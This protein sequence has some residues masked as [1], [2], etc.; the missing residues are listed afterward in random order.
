MFKP[1][2]RAFLE[3][4]RENLGIYTVVIIFF[5]AGI[6]S[7]SVLLRFL[8]ESQLAE[9]N[10]AVSYFM[11]GLKNES[12][13][14]LQPLDLL[15][16]SLQK[17]ILF[18]FMLW[19]L[20]FLWIGFPFIL[21]V[22]ALKGFALGFTVAFIVYRS[23]LKGLIFCLAAVLPHNLL[24]LPAY[25]VAA[26]TALTLSLLKLKERLGKKRTD[27]NHYYRGYCYLMLLL[28]VII[29]MGGLVEAYITPVFMRLVISII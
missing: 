22:L 28:L 2:R 20:G 25:L 16:V 8:K 26:A 11:E 14:M 15:K 12:Y 23:A 17:N 1:M 13:N 24:L 4:L 10:T 5:G 7:G 3:Y 29:L 6:I 21:V 18:H 9:L 19:A 27:R